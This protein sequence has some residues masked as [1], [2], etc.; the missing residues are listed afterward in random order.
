MLDFIIIISK[1]KGNNHNLPLVIVTPSHSKP[2]NFET[3][4]L[5]LSFVLPAILYLITV[6]FIYT[7]EKKK[8]LQQQNIVFVVCLY[9]KS[10]GNC[11]VC[12]IE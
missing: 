7:N 6:S 9:I 11:T 12:F 10:F 2:N 4:L 8:S 3:K 5:S 1:V